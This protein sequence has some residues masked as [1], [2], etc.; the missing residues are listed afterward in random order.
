[1]AEN[2][3]PVRE[4]F[5]ANASYW[6]DEFHFDGLRLDATQQIFDSSAQNIITCIAER[7]RGAAQGRET[8]LVGENEPQDAQLLK[9]PAE[10]GG[11]LD[12]LWNDDFH[13]SAMVALT[14]RNEAYYG[15]YQGTAQEFISMVKYGFLYQG[16]RYQWQRNRRGTP[17]LHLPPAHFITFLQNHDQVANSLQ[18]RRIHE[19]T[20]SPGAL[21]ALDGADPAGTKYAD[22]FPGPGICRLG[23]L[24]LFRGSRTR[25]C[26]AGGGRAPQVSG[27]ISKHRQPG[28]GSR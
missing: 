8:Y 3:A 5:L 26:E 16:Q 15:D 9:P 7:V 18:G 2:S 17:S 22:A 24:P 10:G 1:M 21:R 23:A 19:L 27:A 12:A 20:A 11:G 25:A 4:F 6:I 13:H 14:G 28:A